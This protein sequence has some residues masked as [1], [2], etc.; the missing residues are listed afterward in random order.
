MT[1]KHHKLAAVFIVLAATSFASEPSPHSHAPPK[2]SR[3]KAL[4]NARAAVKKEGYDLKKLYVS[5][6][7]S[8]LSDDG[9]EWVFLFQCAPNPPPDCGFFV[10]VDSISGVARIMPGM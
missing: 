8:H 5:N 6:F 1:G 3:A 2:I 7:I 10:T 4:A 9:K